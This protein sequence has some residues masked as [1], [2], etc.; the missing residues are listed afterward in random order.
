MRGSCLPRARR[1]CKA[2]LTAKHG[3]VS[4]SRLSDGGGQPQGDDAA[5]G[6]IQAHGSAI[7]GLAEPTLGVFVKAEE[8]LILYNAAI[9]FDGRAALS[10]QIQGFAKFQAR[11][12][13]R[14]RRNGGRF[15]CFA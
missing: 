4:G 10:A 13:Q 7:E 9:L 3:A 1:A 11:D 5:S 2:S 12:G 15:G 8:V 6:V 14:Y